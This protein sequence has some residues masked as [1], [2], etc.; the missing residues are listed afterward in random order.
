MFR[1][2]YLALDKLVEQLK[3]IATKKCKLKK[4]T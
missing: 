4:S 2:A 1:L 3:K